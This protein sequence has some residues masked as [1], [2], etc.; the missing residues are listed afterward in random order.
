M[1]S[2]LRQTPEKTFVAPYRPHV[3]QQHEEAASVCQAALLPAVR[4]I[5]KMVGNILSP[6]L[7]ALNRRVAAAVARV[8]QGVYK[9]T[10]KGASIESEGPSFVQQHVS[11]VFDGIAKNQL[12]KLPPEYA[13]MVASSVTAFSI[14]NFVSN[15]AL[16]RPLGES[17]R[18]HITQDL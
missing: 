11:S 15:I 1:T 3:S 16:C 13:S 9:D 10:P 5:E 14:Y 2:Y 7:R 4:Q 8:H 17:A 18:L 6:L 12:A